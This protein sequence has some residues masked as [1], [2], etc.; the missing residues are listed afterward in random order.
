MQFLSQNK[1]AVAGKKVLVRADLNVPI[2]EGGVKDTF[3]I[4]ALLPTISFLKEAGAQIIIASHIEGNHGEGATTMAPVVALLQEYFPVSFV[5]D[6]FPAKNP[7]IDEAFSEGKIVVLEN[8][9]EYGEEKGND[10]VFA[11]HLASYADVYVNEAFSVSHRAHASIV[12]I[13]KFLPS[14]VGLQ[15]EKEIQALSKVFSPARPF[16]FILGGSKFETKL[17]ILKKLYDKADFTFVGGAIANDFFKA[18]GLQ[19][20][21]S[22]V[23]GSEA[24]LSVFNEPKLI[25]PSDVIAAKDT[26]D[27]QTSPVNVAEDEIITDIGVESVNVLRN[28][29]RDAKTII[30]NGPMGNYEKGFVKGTEMVAQVVAETESFTIVG[31]G[32]TVACIRSLGISQKFSFLS[33]AGGAMLEYLLNETLPGIEALG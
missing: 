19:V 9:R 30:W 13:P 7:Q 10:E 21:R 5:K 31:G 12:S 4:E 28:F 15:F 22:L 2:D 33:T 6:Y 16:V 14:Y 23:S 17:P 29:I 1:S 25:L 24:D 32:D 20:G 18:Q 11:K 27:R 8:L 26:K 3:R